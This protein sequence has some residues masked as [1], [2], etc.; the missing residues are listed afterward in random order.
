MK[1]GIRDIPWEIS[2]YL[3]KSLAAPELVETRVGV[4]GWRFLG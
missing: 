2:A 4:V 3:Q 1:V